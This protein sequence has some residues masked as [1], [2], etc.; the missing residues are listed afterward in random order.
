MT[1]L[2]GVARIRFHGPETAFTTRTNID[3]FYD[4]R[5]SAVVP[6]RASRPQGIDLEV[7]GD[8]G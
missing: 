4:L 2:T 7:V 5:L 1:H 3:D 8:T 6:A